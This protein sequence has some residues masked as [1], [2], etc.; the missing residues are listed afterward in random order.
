MKLYFMLPE[1]LSTEIEVVSSY[2]DDIL[3]AHES[4]PTTIKKK[5]L[6]VVVDTDE[7]GARLIIDRHLN[8]IAAQ[9]C[10]AV[11]DLDLYS[12]GFHCSDAKLMSYYTSQRLNLLSVSDEAI[13]DASADNFTQLSNHLAKT[14][15]RFMALEG[16]MT[17]SGILKFRDVM[18]ALLSEMEI[19]GIKVADK[20]NEVLTSDKIH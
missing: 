1:E 6:E 4:L 3:L 7:E 10:A 16:E 8:D 14:V 20:V 18:V 13:F 17:V 15:K 9:G 19:Q 2:V 11:P 5:K 12:I